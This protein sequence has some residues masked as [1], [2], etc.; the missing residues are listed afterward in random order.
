M[1]VPEAD[2]PK[3]MPVLATRQVVSLKKILVP[4]DFSDYASAA[5][6][7]ATKIAS[8]VG[9]QLALLWWPASSKPTTARPFGN[10]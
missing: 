3:S 6:D 8:Q 10:L 9:A 4:L 2:E 7:Y 1:P 5:V